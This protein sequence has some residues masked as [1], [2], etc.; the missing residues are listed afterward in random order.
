M[1]L[2]PHTCHL[3]ALM[4]YL[5]VCLPSPITFVCL[6]VHTCTCLPFATHLHYI[7]LLPFAICCI[8]PVPFVPDILPSLHLTILPFIC[9]TMPFHAFTIYHL[10]DI[11]HIYLPYY[12]LLFHSFLIPYWPPP[13]LPSALPRTLLAFT[14]CVVVAYV[15][16]PCPH[17][18][19]RIYSPAFTRLL[20]LLTGV[21]RSSPRLLPANLG[22]ICLVSLVSGSRPRTYHSLP[23]Y[24]GGSLDITPFH[25]PTLA[26]PLYSFPITRGCPGSLPPTLLL[27]YLYDH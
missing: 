1:P 4:P 12:Y 5:P 20:P 22:G 21:Y 16:Y 11:I 27:F 6:F 13:A 2:L 17:Y 7:P 3:H 19:A 25:T 10:F 23:H 8:L 9:A 14:A 18:Y 26:Y 24:L 15:Y